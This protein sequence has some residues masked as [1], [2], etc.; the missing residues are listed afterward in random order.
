MQ[1]LLTVKF[2]FKELAVPIVG[3]HQVQQ[4]TVITAGEHRSGLHTVKV[5]EDT[6]GHLVFF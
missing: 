3:R 4:G 2:D 5:A 1:G 6:E